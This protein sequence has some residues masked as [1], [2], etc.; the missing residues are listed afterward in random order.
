M[1]Q[2]RAAASAAAADAC[3]WRRR[4]YA[5]SHNAPSLSSVRCLNGWAAAAGGW[6]G[7]RAHASTDLY[8]RS[9]DTS[10]LI[11]IIAHASV[12]AEAA[13]ACIG[14]INISSFD[15]RFVACCTWS[16]ATCLSVLSCRCHCRSPGGS[17]SLRDSV[18]GAVFT[19]AA[20]HD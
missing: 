9:G 12:N 1:M 19:Y 8:V 3:C 7:R 16:T 6:M 2:R 15:G 20:S 11:V 17:H 13:R 4:F 18:L 5:W 10:G 14:P